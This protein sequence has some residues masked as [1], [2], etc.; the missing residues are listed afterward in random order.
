LRAPE[1]LFD[2]P[3]ELVTC[4]QHWQRRVGWPPRQNG[5]HQGENQTSTNVKSIR[6]PKAAGAPG[7]RVK[8]A[9]SP[10]GE[11]INRQRCLIA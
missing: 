4:E 5:Q 8:A 7:L 6:A 1:R 11:G 3:D 10:S 9:A 2:E